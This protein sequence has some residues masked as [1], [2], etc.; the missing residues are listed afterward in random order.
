MISFL[1]ENNLLYI[2]RYKEVAM[3][4]GGQIADMKVA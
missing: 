4:K 3:S 2:C 1:G